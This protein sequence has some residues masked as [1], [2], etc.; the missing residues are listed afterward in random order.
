MPISLLI[1]AYARPEQLGEAL[2]SISRQD[3]SLIGEII[4]GDDSPPIYWPRNQAVIAGSGLSDLV[5]YVPSDPPKGTYPNQWFLASRAK[6]DHVLFPA[7]RRIFFAP[8]HCA[9]WQMR[10][11][12]R[13]IRA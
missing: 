10:V 11:P 1:P 13:A 5:D 8:V 2:E 4:V 6:F 12:T 7:Q 3:R 9:C